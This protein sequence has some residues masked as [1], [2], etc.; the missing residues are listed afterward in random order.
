M[1]RAIVGV[2]ILIGAVLWLPIW[3]QLACFAA[4][5][6]LLPYRVF[7]LVPAIIGDAL[8]MPGSQFNLAS[9]WL[10]L[11]VL[12]MI[13]IHWYAMKKMRVQH[14]YGLEA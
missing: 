2:I 9:H 1:I 7:F 10:T 8:Y 13:I 6:I 12:G 3:V 14:L 11:I 5:V 4:A